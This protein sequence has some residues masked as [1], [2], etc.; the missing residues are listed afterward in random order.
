MFNYLDIE[1]TQNYDLTVSMSAKSYSSILK[2]LYFSCY[3]N[4]DHSEELLSYLTE[5]AF[6]DRLVAGISDNIKV[7]HKIGVVSETNQSDCGII[8]LNKRNYTLCIM[9]NGPDD[10]SLNPHFKALSKKT[11]DYLKSLQ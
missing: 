5:S 2:C 3:L 10:G 1:I 6:N 9:L 11:Y 4:K 8:Y 7:A